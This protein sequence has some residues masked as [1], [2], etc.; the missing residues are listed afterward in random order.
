MDTPFLSAGFVRKLR[1]SPAFE[2]EREKD[3]GERMVFWIKMLYFHYRYAFN[4][5][6]LYKKE[7]LILQTRFSVMSLSQVKGSLIQEVQ[8]FSAV[9]LS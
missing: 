5:C 1:D 6:Y 2:K 8:L 3:Q 9:V 7:F 4:Y